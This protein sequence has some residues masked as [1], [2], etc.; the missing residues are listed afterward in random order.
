MDAVRVLIVS[1]GDWHDYARGAE[2]MTTALKAAGHEVTA[3]QDGAA[4]K[5]LG[6][7]QVVVLY[8]QGDKFKED[9]VE[10]LAQFV[11]GGGGLVGIHSASDTNTKSA[12]Y[13]KLIGS[14]FITH[15]P[16]FDFNVTVS[17][18]T[19]PIAHRIQSFRIHDELYVLQ[20]Q[21][22]FQTFM[23]AWWD[24]KPQPMAYTRN[25][26]SGRVVYFANG[27]WATAL[28]NPAWQQIFNRG[29]R[30]AAGEDWSK[31]TVKVSAIGY[32]GAFNMGKMHLESCK[33]AGLTP[34]AVC[35]VDP[36]RVATAKTELG[37]HIQTFTKVDELLS[38]SDAEMCIIITP[39]NT[40]APLALQ[41]LEAGRHVVSEKPFVITVDEATKVIDT[42]RRAKK[43]ATVFHNRRWDAHFLTIKKIVES[44]AIG[45]IFQMECQMGGY[46]EQKTD[47]WRSYK[48][49]SGG[50]IYDWGAHITDWTLQ[51]MPY[52]IEAV[53]GFFVKKMW[54]QV[55]NEDHTVAFIHFEGGRRAQV[56]LSALAAVGKSPMRILGTKG[57]IEIDNLWDKTP[58]LKLVEF[59][60]F[61]RKESRVPYIEG[62]W[63]GFYRNV[64]DH[65]L[66]GEPLLVTPESARK[67]IAVLSLAEESSKKG[68]ALVGIPFEQ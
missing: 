39:H 41:C 18:P 19:H 40:H 60:D 44:G 32:G 31:K 8:T 17:D 46:G 43:M 38:K 24:G 52:K 9:E 49:V 65:L 34:S 12:A 35:D 68:G 13:M 37:E 62:D 59:G 10:G 25:E 4:L 7:Y 14:K 58:G 48:D 26:G 29:V 67:V 36:K 47:W 2:V 23:T 33:K 20:P 50:F 5:S 56:E 21:A 11:R 64:A 6:K 45:E 42:A 28:E 57:G 54:H 1:G 51:L 55:S 61:G 66:L 3:T 63:D 16:V 53:S 27:H 30:Y 22:E 15:G